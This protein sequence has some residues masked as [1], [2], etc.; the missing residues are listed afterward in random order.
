MGQQNAQMAK[1]A[2]GIRH[3]TCV[4]Y[5]DGV[6]TCREWIRKTKV[7]MELNLERDVKSN[8]KGFYR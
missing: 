6:Q 5:R 7:Q 8:K 2:N 3:V 4:E 1:K